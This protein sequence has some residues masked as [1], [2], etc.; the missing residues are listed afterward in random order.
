VSLSREA[1]V[2]GVVVDTTDFY[3][4]LKVK[5]QEGIWQ[6]VEF[7][8]HKMGRG[9]ARV[10]TKLKNLENG[11]IVENTFRS[12]DRFERIMFEEK[13]A[14]YLYR[15]GDTYFFM[16]LSTYNQMEIPKDVLGDI[17]YYLSENLEVQLEEFEGKIMGIE[18]PK[19]VELVVADT[20]PGYKGDTVSGSGKPAKCSTGLSV[21][22]PIFVNS[23]DS[24][25][26]DT[27]TG[28]YI[29]RAKK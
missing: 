26:V 13:P 11:S 25:I 2:M 10:Q 20:P 29:E 16:D 3:V 24:I 14:Q 15:E 27:R 23:G 21:N 17:V 6:I 22:V 1:L 9:G 19:S 18:L 7:Q 12:G 4:G 8:H 5:W 28:A